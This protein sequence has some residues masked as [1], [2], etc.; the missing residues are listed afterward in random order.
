MKWQ[1][2]LFLVL[3]KKCYQ[4][5][6][7]KKAKGRV[8]SRVLTIDGILTIQWSLLLL[9]FLSDPTPARKIE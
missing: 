8:T 2:R 5:A 6:A 7:K 3:D 9:P 1:R 4:N